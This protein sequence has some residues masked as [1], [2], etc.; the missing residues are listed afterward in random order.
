MI[1]ERDV[2]MKTILVKKQKKSF[3]EESLTHNR[4]TSITMSNSRTKLSLN[5]VETQKSYAN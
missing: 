3:F 2:T 5:F 1:C 4:R